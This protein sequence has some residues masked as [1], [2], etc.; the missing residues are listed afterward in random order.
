[1][2][3]N[4]SCPWSWSH[5][6]N[7]PY[8]SFD[9]LLPTITNIINTSLASGLVPPN[10]KTAIVKTAISTQTPCT[11]PRKQP[12]QSFPISLPHRTQHRDR[13]PTRCKRLVKRYGWRQNLCFTLTGSFNCVWYYWSPDSSFTS[14]NCL[15]H[16]LYRSP[17]VSIIPSGQKS[18][19]GCQQFC[20]F[21]FSSRVWFPQGS[22]L[23]PV[24]FVLYTTP[25]SDIIA[26]NSVNHQ[27]FAD[28]TQLQK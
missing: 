4:W 27:L 20:F 14:R 23:G 19:R 11:P 5:S 8:E 9:V 24:L 25:F 3:V 18:V 10:F 28:D 26:N 17:V 13:T 12:L 21:F 7:F 1:M 6:L 15:W 22:V 16:P 2:H